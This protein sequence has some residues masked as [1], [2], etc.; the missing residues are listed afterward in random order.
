MHLENNTLPQMKNLKWWGELHFDIGQARVWRFGSL[1]VRIKR[2]LNEWQLEYHRPRHQDAYLQDWETLDIETAFSEPTVLERYLF[3]RTSDTLSIYP[4]LANR[5]VIV[6]PINPIFIPPG[7]QGTMF[8][9][10]PLW[11]AGF[12]EGQKESIFDISIN[13]PKDSW[14]GPDAK[15]GELCYA[16]PVDG[17]TEIKQLEQ[18]AFRAITPIHFHNTSNAMM[19]LN[20]MNLPVP[21]LPLFHSSENGRLWTSQIKVIQDAPNRAPRIKIENRTPPQ[22]GKVAFIQPPRF[23]DGSLFN[24]FDSFF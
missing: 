17:R 21:A 6:K 16:T 19:Q 15:K 11:M 14:F 2:N 7:Q 10:T 24:M 9:S 22:A 18:L 12:V 23:G 3:A 4:R 20:R 8:V 1:Y 5:S 13:R